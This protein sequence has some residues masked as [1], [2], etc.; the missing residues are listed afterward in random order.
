MFVP[1]EQLEPVEA[2]S[3]LERSSVSTSP[4]SGASELVQPDLLFWIELDVA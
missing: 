4:L 3:T 1:V 2:R